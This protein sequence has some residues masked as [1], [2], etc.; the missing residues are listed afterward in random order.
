MRKRWFRRRPDGRRSKGQSLVEF[1]LT[2]PVILGLTLIAL[3]FGRVYL[4]YINLQNMA[5]IAANFAANNPEAWGSKPISSLQTQYRNQILSDAKATNCDLPK[6]GGS[7]VVPAPVF[8]DMNGDGQT[9]LGDSVRVRLDCTFGVI[10]P[11]ISAVLGG[12]VQVGAESSFPVKSGMSAVKPAPAEVPLPVAQFI[13]N[14]TT[15]SPDPLTISGATSS[16]SF[17]DTSGGS[18][19]IWAWDFN[20]DGTIDAKTQDVHTFD[21]AQPSC[22]YRVRLTAT[23]ASGDATTSM[24]VTVIGTSLVNFN[25]TTPNGVA[26]LTVTFMDTSV[27]GGSNPTWDFGDGTTGTGSQVAHTYSDT[28]GSPYAVSLTVTYPDPT[29]TQTTTKK[30]YVTVGDQMCKI[31]FLS[32]QR[33]NDAQAIWTGAQFTGQVLRGAGAPSGNFIITAQSLT[34]GET[35]VCSSDIEVNRP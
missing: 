27:S 21:C 4:G 16:V 15:L 8:S 22:S 19:T 1:A 34:G 3:D 5:R 32:A 24:G 14:D 25:S 18:P 2:L 29:G 10:T 23:N 31:P 12:S 11:F 7:P 35:A 33:F 30:A 26:P 17:R 28:A 20:D 6:A 13:A 9:D